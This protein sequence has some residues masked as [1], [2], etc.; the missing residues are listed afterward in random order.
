MFNNGKSSHFRMLKVSKKLFE[1]NSGIRIC[2]LMW[3]NELKITFSVNINRYKAQ[4]SIKM[5]K[6]LVLKYH[7]HLAITHMGM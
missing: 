4:N 3:L 7:M 6:S 1:R 5:H 2:L